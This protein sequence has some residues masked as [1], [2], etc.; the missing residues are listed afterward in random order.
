MATGNHPSTTADLTDQVAWSTASVDVATVSATGVVT[1]TGPGIIQITAS[2]NG[3]TGKITASTTITVT[4]S[5]RNQF[6]GSDVNLD[7]DH[8]ILSIGR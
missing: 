5:R 2:I 6:H 4:G 1:A 3:Y 8:P 7:R